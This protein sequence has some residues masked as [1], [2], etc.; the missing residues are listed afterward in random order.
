MSTAQNMRILDY[1]DKH[2]TIT[3]YEAWEKLG[4]YRLS[5]RI[6]ELREIGVN[7]GKN[8]LKVQ[9]RFGEDCRIAEYSLIKTENEK[10]VKNT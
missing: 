3:P 2:G 6:Y 8:I 5:A 1:L 10:S 9:N 4:I 7:I